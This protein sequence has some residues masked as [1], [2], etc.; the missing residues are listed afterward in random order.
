MAS[1]SAWAC[2]T[3]TPGF[4]RPTISS[5]ENRR[6]SSTGNSRAISGMICPAIAIGVQRS[7]SVSRLTPTTP[8]GV[9]PTIVKGWL[10]S[11]TVRPMTSSL[12]PKTRR[13]R[14]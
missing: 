6:V 2:A 7:G 8:G 1:S 11:R 13:H 5:H 3:V 12:P 4:I 9:T 14:P 10:L